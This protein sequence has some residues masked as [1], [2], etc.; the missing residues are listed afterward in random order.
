VEARESL[1]ELNLKEVKLD[2][3]IKIKEVGKKLSGYSGAD[4]TSVCR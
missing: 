1:L 4:I 2:N 3:D